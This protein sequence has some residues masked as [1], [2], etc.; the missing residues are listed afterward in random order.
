MSKEKW[1][2]CQICSNKTRIEAHHDTVLENFLLY[3]PKCKQETIINVKEYLDRSSN[4]R[5]EIGCPF[6][7]PTGRKDRPPTTKPRE[8][9]REDLTARIEDGKKK[10]RHVLYAA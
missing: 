9:T 3:C 6:S 5:T 1:M 10:K 7:M 8:K 4:F 2:L